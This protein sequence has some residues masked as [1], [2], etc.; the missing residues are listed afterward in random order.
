MRTVGWVLA[1][2]FAIAGCRPSPA[3]GLQIG[4]EAPGF[5]LP[6][7]GGTQ[8]ALSDFTGVSPVLLFF[9]MAVG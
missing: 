3:V 1:V 2:S 5:S 6:A 7:V 8:V 4:E 9:H